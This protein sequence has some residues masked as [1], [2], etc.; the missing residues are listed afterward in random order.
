MNED[1][2]SFDLAKKLKEKG[3]NVPCIYA[4]CEKGGWN[5]YTQK[6]EPITHILRTDGNPFGSYYTGD[7]WN[8]EYKPNKNKIRCSAPTISQVL[9]WLR[10]E[11]SIFA[12][13]CILADADTDADGNVINE[14]TY[15]SFSVTNIETG[16]MIYF[17]YEH[18]DDKRFDSYEQAAIASI[19]YC[20]DDLI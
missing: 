12:E 17:E 11:K 18:V 19:E 15:W 14:Y 13:P 8:K 9:K 4:Y 5:S 16:D 3:F 10:E 2:V 7:N 1:F 6:H 20:L